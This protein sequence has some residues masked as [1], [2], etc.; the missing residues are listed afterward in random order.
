[1]LKKIFYGFAILLVLALAAFLTMFYNLARQSETIVNAGLQNDLLQ[2][3]PNRPSCVN[4]LSNIE[5]HAIAAFSVPADMTEPVTLMATLIMTMPRADILEI[6]NDY[7]H[8]KF[9]SAIFGF[10]DDLELLRDGTQLQVRSV[11]RVGFSDMG[12][13]RKR[14]EELRS[15]WLQAQN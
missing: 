11:S 4:S 9:S 5:E 2:E 7:L 15:L 13:N 10:S 1:M 8:A 6:N 12:V 3:C 14:V